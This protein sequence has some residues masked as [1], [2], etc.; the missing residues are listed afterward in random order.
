MSD[1]KEDKLAPAADIETEAASW[2]QRRRYWN[3]SDEDQVALEKWLDESLAHSV[4]YWRL[5]AGLGRA[6]RLVALRGSAP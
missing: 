6:E 5:D 2:L 3:W 1:M 4:A